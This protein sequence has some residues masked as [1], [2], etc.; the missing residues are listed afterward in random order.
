MIV[1]SVN[2]KKRLG[3][4][5]ARERF[6]SW[7]ER[8]EVTLVVVQEAWRAGGPAPPPPPG[9][10]FLEG[11]AELAAWIRDGIDRP[12]VDRPEDVVADRVRR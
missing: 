2:A 3:A 8:R 10:Q 1:A 5:G 11:D 4:V 6:G 7:L 9:M 12:R